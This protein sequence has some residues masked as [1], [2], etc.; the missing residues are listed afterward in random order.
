MSDPEVPQNDKPNDIDDV[1][2]S[3]NEGLDAAAAARAE[4]PADSAEPHSDADMEAFAAAER[5]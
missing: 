4:A 1:V 3:A 2:G 5:D